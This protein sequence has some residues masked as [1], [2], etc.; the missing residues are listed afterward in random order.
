MPSL[1]HWASKATDFSSDSR[2]AAVKA[3]NKVE[4]FIEYLDKSDE[5]DIEEG[6]G[7]EEYYDSQDEN[8][9]QEEY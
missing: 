9:S 2:L 3:E 4:D 6:E 1:C 7:E 5:S 8:G